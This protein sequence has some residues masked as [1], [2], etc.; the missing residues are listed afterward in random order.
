MRDITINGADI[1]WFNKIAQELGYKLD[2]Y[3]FET[4]PP[5]CDSL[6][7]PML[8]MERKDGVMEKIGETDMSDGQL[9]AILDQRKVI[10]TGSYIS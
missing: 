5:I 10:T 8:F 4:K 7:K 3:Y 9:R 6:K 1:L 2:I